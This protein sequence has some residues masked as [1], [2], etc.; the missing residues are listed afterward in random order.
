MGLSRKR[1]KQIKQLASNRR[2]P[3]QV[4][5]SAK[6]KLVSK[7]KI[8]KL[9]KDFQA[10]ICRKELRFKCR[11]YLIGS[12]CFLRFLRKQFTLKMAHGCLRSSLNQRVGSIGEQAFAKTVEPY[13]YQPFSISSKL[14]FVAAAADFILLNHHPKLIEI[15]TSKTIEGC[16]QIFQNPSA[17]YLVQIWTAMELFGLSN[18]ELLIYHYEE[19]GKRRNKF[20]FFKF[21]KLFARIIITWTASLFS[22]EV[23]FNAIVNYIEFVGKYLRA[24][25]IK[26]SQSDLQNLQSNMIV[27][28][29]RH[30]SA[31]SSLK[32]IRNLL[33]LRPQ[34]DLNN[35]CFALAGF[36]PD[37]E[38]YGTT[39]R[40]QFEKE[41]YSNVRENLDLRLIELLRSKPIERE[42]T[43][44]VDLREK[45]TKVDRTN[46][47]EKK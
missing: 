44:N 24:N 30:K 7:P 27:C 29:S 17:D 28:A 41:R 3:K 26:F 40:A 33:R 31:R 23:V 34:R 21:T 47:E 19:S 10:L 25:N 9:T 14:P 20:G 12:S 32:N 38:R 37:F 35:L 43:F 45:L 39:S 42:L 36:D 13:L 2:H 18:A 6:K 46:A 22:D 16:E 11:H 8:S 5:E 4:K 15:K 1:I